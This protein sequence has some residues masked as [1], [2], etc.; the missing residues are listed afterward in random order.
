MANYLMEQGVPEE[1]I[2]IEN[3]S[4]TTFENLTFILEKEGLGKHVLV[5]TN[6]FHTLRAGVFMRRLRIP[7]RSVGS[8]TAFYYLPSAWIRETV[9]LVS[10]L[11]M[12]CCLF[13]FSLSA[14]VLFTS[15]ATD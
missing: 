2:L 11:E 12:A 13:S 3:R 4:R 5:V 15:H 1:D 6:S 8:K 10:L 9:G 7:G 14:L